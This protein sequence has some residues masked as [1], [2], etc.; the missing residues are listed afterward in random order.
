VSL[1]FDAFPTSGSGGVIPSPGQPIVTPPAVSV[2][3]VGNPIVYF[4]TGYQDN[5]S[6]SD[7]RNVLWAVTEKVDLVA[8]KL[9]AQALWHVGFGE[10]TSSGVSTNW[11][12][13]TRV[14]GPLSVFNGAVYFATYTPPTGSTAVCQLSDSTVWAVDYANSN[15]AGNFD[16]KP[17][18]V[19]PT[20]GITTPVLGV[21]QKNQI[22]FG[23]GV[24]KS[25]PCFDTST[26]SDDFVGYGSSSTYVSNG[27]GGDFRL[28]WQSSPN[29]KAK[30]GDQAT[31]TN[32]VQLQ[33]PASGVR[34]TSWA[35]VLE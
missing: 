24:T 5:F 3:Q 25:P 4:S 6:S 7:T 22:I 17:M 19:S 34:I 29:G 33:P 13:G 2:D 14:T 23:V 1:F 20:L 26:F 16:P 30:T 32:T 10:T 21:V 8:N 9:A 27:N 12:Q 31:Q 11:V 35:S 28:V 18:F 15:T